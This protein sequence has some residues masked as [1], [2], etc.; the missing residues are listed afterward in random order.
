[1]GRSGK[2]WTTAHAHVARVGC[3]QDW[4]EKKLPRADAGAIGSLK[5]EHAEKLMFF[6]LPSP[7][8]LVGSWGFR[9]LNW[10][11]LGE[12]HH[13][14]ESPTQLPVFLDLPGQERCHPCSPL[15]AALV[16]WLGGNWNINRGHPIPALG[17]PQQQRFPPSLLLSL[18]QPGVN[19]VP[20]AVTFGT[21]VAD[22]WR[23]LDRGE[24]SPLRVGHLHPWT[25]DSTLGGRRNS[26]CNLEWSGQRVAE[27]FF[28][29]FE[30]F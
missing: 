14:G 11:T 6:V 19:L 8:W 20:K 13:Q 5:V 30:V 12:Q 10:Q 9:F 26:W 15:G 2:A 25:P 29:F 17:G 24:D 28:F 23:V 27:V 16:G 4:A 7:G 3:T 21:R 1:M 22:Q 18:L